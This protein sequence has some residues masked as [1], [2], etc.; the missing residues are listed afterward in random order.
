MSLAKAVDYQS[1]CD[2][3]LAA[4][5]K[6]QKDVHGQADDRSLQHLDKLQKCKTV[7]AKQLF[8]PIARRHAT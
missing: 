7:A 4:I 2:H 3:H 8:D 6:E 5:E 1:V